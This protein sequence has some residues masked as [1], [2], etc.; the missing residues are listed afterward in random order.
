EVDAD[1]GA[2]RVGARNHDRATHHQQVG[3]TAGIEGQPFVM[4]GVLVAVGTG[5]DHVERAQYR[6]CVQGAQSL[7]LRVTSDGAALDQHGA[8][9][10]LLDQ[11]AKGTW[12]VCVVVLGDG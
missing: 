6:R 5:G 3:G 11:V 4:I 2:D 1:V 7:L 10:P 8:G 12:F 9:P